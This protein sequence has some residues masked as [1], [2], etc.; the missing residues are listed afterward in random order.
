MLRKAM[1]SIMRW[2][3]FDIGLV[4]GVRLRNRKK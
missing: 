4:I 1:S 2:R 3:S